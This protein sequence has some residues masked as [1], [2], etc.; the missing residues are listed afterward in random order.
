MTTDVGGHG[1]EHGQGVLSHSHLVPPVLFAVVQRR[2]LSGVTNRA[3]GQVVDVPHTLAPVSRPKTTV[4]PPFA[5][6]ILPE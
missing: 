3:Y 5:P 2:G 4:P 1:H 6:I